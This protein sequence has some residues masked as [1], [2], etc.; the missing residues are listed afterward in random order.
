MRTVLT[1]LGVII[2]V[3]A[4]IAM[5]EISRGASVAIQVTVTKMGANTLAGHC[6]APRSAGRGGSA[7]RPRSSRPTTPTPSSAN[8]PTVVCT[9]PIVEA[10]GQ[11]VYGNRESGFRST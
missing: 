2:G 5:M 10:W 7:K 11:V 3:A 1:M 4:V 6:P 8:A 9:A